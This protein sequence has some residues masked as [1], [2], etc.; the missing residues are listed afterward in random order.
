MKSLY[1][2]IQVIISIQCLP[3]VKAVNGLMGRG[4]GGGGGIFVN[5][6]V[7]KKGNLDSCQKKGNLDSCQKKGNLDSCQKREF[8]LMPKKGN[9]E[10]DFL[11]PMRDAPLAYSQIPN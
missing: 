5:G 11:G 2:S 7:P 1:C 9:L 3:Q 10:W 8:G 6:L 4:G